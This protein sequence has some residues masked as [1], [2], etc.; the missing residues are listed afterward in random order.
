MGFI[1]LLL[2]LFLALPIIGNKI[3]YADNLDGY[4]PPPMFG[5]PR[6]VED[7]PAYKNS[8]TP[9]AKQPKTTE[10]IVTKTKPSR[11]NTTNH[12]VIPRAEKIDT[13]IKPSVIPKKAQPKKQ[14]VAPK[15]AKK[16][17]PKTVK[18]IKPSKQKTKA[19]IKKD[20]RRVEPIT[21]TLQKASKEPVQQKVISDNKPKV[22][23]KKPEHPKEKFREP[24]KSVKLPSE[25]TAKIKPTDN[26]SLE[27]IDLINK[28]KKVTSQGIVKGPKTMPAYKKQGV[29]SE[30]L[31]APETNKPANLIDRVQEKL[32]KK[33]VVT[34]EQKSKKIQPSANF[35]LPQ[36]NVMADGA[37]KLNIIFDNK[38]KNSLNNDQKYTVQEMILPLL[39]ENSAMRLRLESYASPNDKSLSADKRLSLSRVMAMRQYFIDNEIN[40]SRLD[41]R[42][43]GASS[44]SPPYD[45]IDIYIL[46]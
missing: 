8:K 44:Q 38:D 41:I 13:P 12:L 42:S 45:R 25:N 34:E 20:G 39:K 35:S 29:E 40:P 4:V 19:I 6:I 11:K 37:K 36:F 23:I 32:F 27:P 18:Q 43:L 2:F 14:A 17:K 31:Y 5:A 15:P 28:K 1:K 7:D 26:T 33:K 30:V 22:I 24:L 16:K 46:K 21:E 9:T 3:S 10:P